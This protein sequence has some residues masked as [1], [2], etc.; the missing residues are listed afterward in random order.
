MTLTQKS[1]FTQ[2]STAN[3]PGQQEIRGQRPL[4]VIA[5]PCPGLPSS[6]H[7]ALGGDRVEEA[8]PLL[9]HLGLEVTWA[10]SAQIPLLRPTHMASQRY[11]RG[12]PCPARRPWLVPG[13]RG[14]GEQAAPPQSSLPSLLLP[15]PVRVNVHTHRHYSVRPP[16]TG[17]LFPASP[18]N[19]CTHHV[20][21]ADESFRD[22]QNAIE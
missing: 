14:C 1:L 9:D 18:T 17:C 2:L 11:E 4:H 16:P 6:W 20:R 10:T 12:A 13:G 22:Q 5:V 7:W 19:V 8:H 21:P 15:S 3:G